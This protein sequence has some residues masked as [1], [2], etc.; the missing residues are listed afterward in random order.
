MPWA[1]GCRCSQA[2]ARRAEGRSGGRGATP[3]GVTRRYRRDTLCHVPFGGTMVR[4]G[5]GPHP[6]ACH[7][8]LRPGPPGQRAVAGRSPRLAGQPG[9]GRGPR[10]IR[11][12]PALHC[13]R[14][15][16]AAGAEQAATARRGLAGAPGVRR[17]CRRAWRAVAGHHRAVPGAA[18]VVLGQPLHGQRA[19][20]RGGGGVRPLPAGG[21]PAQRDR[22]LRRAA[23]GGD[24]APGDAAVP[25]TTRDRS[26]PTARPGAMAGAA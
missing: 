22:H 25:W 13:G 5:N 12:A 10:S 2:G 14:P 15:D 20:G 7:D 3:A 26:A 8:P 18:G 17:R 23:A 11:P 21:D 6:H 16:A 9:G 19:A 4:S 24:A 1:T